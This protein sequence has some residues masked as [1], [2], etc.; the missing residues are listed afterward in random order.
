MAGMMQMCPMAVPGTQVSAA[1]TAGGE[2]ITFTTTPD[3]LADLRSR[4]GAM[5]DMHN[6][7]HQGGG[8]DSMHAGGMQGMHG[9]MMGGGAGAMHGGMMPPPSRAV[10][11]DVAGGARIVV[12]PNDPADLDP[13]RTTLRAHAQHMQ[14][15]GQCGM[16][17]AGGM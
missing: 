6:Q 1:D 16:G 2:A 12:T 14:E 9:G 4:V 5:A 3:A 10:V 11:E 8:A 7:H 17:P 13:L 15:T